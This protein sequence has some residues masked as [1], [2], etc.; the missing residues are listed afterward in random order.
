MALNIPVLP[1]A[2]NTLPAEMI[3]QLQAVSISDDGSDL[4]KQISHVNFEQIVLP[5]PPRLHSTT[6]IAD[7]PETRTELMARYAN[8]IIELGASGKVRQRGALSSFCIPN[9]DLD[10]E[11][12]KLREGD[13]PRSPYYLSLLGKE[14][15]ALETHARNSGCKLMIDP[16]IDF[17]DLGPTVTKARLT[18]LLEFLESMPDEKLQIVITSRAREGNLTIVGDWFVAESLT[19]RTGLGYKQTIFSWHAPTVLRWM[20]RFDQEFNSLTE[21]SNLQGIS[22]RQLAIDTIKEIISRLPESKGPD[23]NLSISATH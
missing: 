18:P 11:I 15:R 21:R 8:H 22:S 4:S 14:R 2:V 20:R 23:D 16:T 12:W 9:K 6:E 19:P 13:R 5:P 3:S 17:S 7:W 1:I 10:D